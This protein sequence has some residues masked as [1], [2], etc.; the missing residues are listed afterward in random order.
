LLRGRLKLETQILEGK[1]AVSVIEGNITVSVV[2]VV[3]VSFSIDSFHSDDGLGFGLGP[4]A[5]YSALSDQEHVF[6]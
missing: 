6:N 4:E 1:V 3:H 2:A 5:R